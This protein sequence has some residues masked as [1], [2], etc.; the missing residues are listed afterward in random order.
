MYFKD[1]SNYIN[2]NEEVEPNTYMIGWLDEKHDFPKGEV[3]PSTL[4]RILALCFIPIR[5][6]RGIHRSPFL[7]PAPTGYP[8]VYKGKK[9]HLGSAE[10]IVEGKTGRIYRAPN[11]LYHYIK[12]CG[13]LPPK[14]FIEAVDELDME[15]V[16]EKIKKY[17]KYHTIL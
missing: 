12:D 15:E 10:I 1:L 5:L 11:L 4:E 14:E 16:E 17:S 13:Y 3:S 2:R 7:N 8:V 6:T 9:T